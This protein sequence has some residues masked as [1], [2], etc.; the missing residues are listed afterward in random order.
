MARL[1]TK[2][3][4]TKLLKCFLWPVKKTVVL[5]SSFLWKSSL[6]NQKQK[7]NQS[8]VSLSAAIL[9]LRIFALFFMIIVIP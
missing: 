9:L 6:K 5:K 1:K 2:T 8:F 3:T 4:R 7:K